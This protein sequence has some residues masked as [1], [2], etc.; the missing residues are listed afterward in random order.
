MHLEIGHVIAAI[1]GGILAAGTGWLLYTA[2][3]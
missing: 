1:I 3:H 2:P